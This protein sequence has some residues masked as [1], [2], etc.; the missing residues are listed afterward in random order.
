MVS[1][2]VPC[3]RCRLPAC[4]RASMRLDRRCIC[5]SQTP[6]PPATRSGYTGAL[7]TLC[8]SRISW[9]RAR[10]S[11]SKH[12]VYL[13][14]LCA[15]GCA[16]RA[17][18]VSDGEHQVCLFCSLV[19]YTVSPPVFIVTGPLRFCSGSADSLRQVLVSS[20]LGYMSPLTRCASIWRAMHWPALSATSG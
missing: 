18:A 7:R 19:V 2:A 12:T 11:A 17:H 15:D 8:P 16:T 13:S 9:R 10:S 3:F 4:Q 20:G 14:H 5:L 6:H 1:N